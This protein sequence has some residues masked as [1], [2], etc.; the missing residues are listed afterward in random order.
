MNNDQCKWC[1]IKPTPNRRYS[2][3]KN[4]WNKEKLM[5]RWWMR[6]SINLKKPHKSRTN[7]VTPITALKKNDCHTKYSDPCTTAQK[8]LNVHA[9]LWCVHLLPHLKRHLPH[10]HYLSPLHCC[11]KLHFVLF[12]G[13][14]T[15]GGATP[16]DDVLGP[17][18][19]GTWYSESA[20]TG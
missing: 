3:H 17:P 20:P 2:S 1:H 18:V 14:T 10:I 12:A 13:S 11:T 7:A 16:A 4:T 5:A 9:H 6:W 15:V 19:K 8:W